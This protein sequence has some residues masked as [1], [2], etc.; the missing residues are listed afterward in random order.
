MMYAQV[1]GGLIVLLVSG[2]ILVRSAVSLSRRLGVSPLVVGLTVVAMGTSM[3]EL[4]VV[5]DAALMDAALNQA[6]EISIGNVVGSNIA[7]VLLVL[8]VLALIRPV[9]CD[10]KGLRIDTAVMV[11]ASLVFAVVCMG[12]VV[13]RWQG[14][15][16]AAAL[17]GYIAWCYRAALGGRGPDDHYTD[18][19]EEYENAGRPLWRSVFYILGGVAGL[20]VGADVLIDGAVALAHTAGVSET[21]IGLTVIALG[22]SL[23]ELATALMAIVH[24]HSSLAIGNVLGSNL[25]NILG[26]VG[27][28]AVVVPLPVPPGILD[29][30]LWIMIAV[31]AA[32][33]PFVWRRAPVGRAA[34]VVFLVGYLAYIL[35]QFW[36][37]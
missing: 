17:A 2:D 10:A 25:F 34:G 27:V 4:V 36:N 16:M 26:V 3:P 35:A 19:V 15:V 12:D 32:V 22:T 9:A 28:T 6:A 7:N 23:P 8:G 31:A 30:D 18:E 14:A 33:L 13:G 1:I 21:V 20:I 37:I 11:A 29:F 24:R 5:L